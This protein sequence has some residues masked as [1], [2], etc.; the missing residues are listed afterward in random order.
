MGVQAK[1]LVDRMEERGKGGGAVDV[2]DESWWF[3]NK[4]HMAL[5]QQ[6]IV[7]RFRN[8]SGGGLA[9]PAWAGLTMGGGGASDAASGEVQSRTRTGDLFQLTA[10]M[11]LAF[12]IDEIGGEATWK[13]A[14]EF[15]EEEV[16]S[17]ASDGDERSQ[18]TVS[19]NSDDKE[20]DDA[21]HVLRCYLPEPS[22]SDEEG[23]VGESHGAEASEGVGETGSSG[24]SG[25]KLEKM[26][27]LM[28][29]HKK[30]CDASGAGFTALVFVSTRK[31]A[32]ATPEMLEAVPGLKPFVKAKYIVGLADMTPADQRVALRLLRDGP[33]NVLIST[34]V[35]GE[36]IDVPACGLVIC[37]S[38]PNS[39]T[40][41]VQLRGR[42]RCGENCR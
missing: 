37:A 38:L 16:A 2:D 34:S 12:A 15:L 27:T 14:L 36:G 20:R 11:N 1:K 5:V 17:T 8:G 39:G 41:L 33:V 22:S 4:A 9:G 10:I 21:L 18:E 26:A 25:S 31:L 7:T 35:C 40:A 23:A 6:A 13:W 32:M 30:R 3:P 24:L 28:E 19:R 42:I 29:E